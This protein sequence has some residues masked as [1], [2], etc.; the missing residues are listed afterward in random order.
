MT[1]SFERTPNP[2]VALFRK[3]DY[4]TGYDSVIVV[5]ADK[6]E[7]SPMFS[8]IRKVVPG[9]EEMHILTNGFGF[10]KHP[11]IE[12]SDIYPALAAVIDD[13]VSAH[14]SIVETNSDTS[15]NSVQTSREWDPDSVEYRIDELLVSR[16]RPAVMQDGGDVELVEF[17]DGIAYMRMHGSC[18][19]CPSSTATLKLGIERILT[20]FLDEVT[21]VV[22]V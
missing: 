14:L 15:L 16:I 11:D 6:D 12:W 19:S 5:T 9:L 10:K 1:F 2:S 13:C 17:K 7:S 3:E 20:H 4:K 18:T 21:E 22:A 8:E